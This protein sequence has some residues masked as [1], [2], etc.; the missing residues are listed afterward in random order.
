MSIRVCI[1]EESDGTRSVVTADKT[2]PEISRIAEQVVGK[3]DLSLDDKKCYT[4]Q[5]YMYC[6]IIEDEICYFC[7]AA[8]TGKIRICFSFLETIK[9]E[10]LSKYSGK[11]QSDNFKSYI[12]KQIDYF[13]QNPDVDKIQGI[14]RTVEE[15]RAIALDNMQ[16]L[17]TREG[18]LE[19]LVAESDALETHSNE[20]VRSTE[21]LRCQ[22]CK[23]NVKYT[24]IMIIAILVCLF[25][26]FTILFLVIYIPIKVASDRNN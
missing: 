18:R 2:S 26:V 6:Y 1:V 21:R 4:S 12:Q 10:Y 14:R 22:L 23:Q 20:F 15:V 17:L 25:V 5:G 16:L 7:T 11:V 13:N 3:V 24:I 9:K 8:E 19:E